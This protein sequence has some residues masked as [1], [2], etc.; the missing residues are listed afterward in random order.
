M[1]K[2]SNHDQVNIKGLM[3]RRDVQTRNQI[4]VQ[5]NSQSDLEPID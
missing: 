4:L 2:Y 5:I 1:V 3:R